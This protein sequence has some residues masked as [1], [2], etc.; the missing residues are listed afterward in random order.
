MACARK[1]PGWQVQP[2][3]PSGEEQVVEKGS[4]TFNWQRF[5]AAKEGLR[6]VSDFLAGR[7]AANYE[8]LPSRILREGPFGSPAPRAQD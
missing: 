1:K 4:Q 8:A 3:R 2:T 7:G 6:L 5:K